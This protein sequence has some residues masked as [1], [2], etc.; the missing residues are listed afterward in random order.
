MYKINTDTYTTYNN[1]LFS[2]FN[3]ASKSLIYNNFKNNYLASRVTAPATTGDA[4]LVPE[5]VLQLPL[6]LDPLTAEP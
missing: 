2:V 3:A 5:R 6:I 4:T 1:N